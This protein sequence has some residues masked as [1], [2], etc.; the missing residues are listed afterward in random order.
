MRENLSKAECNAVKKQILDAIAYVR[1]QMGY[2]LIS[3]DWGSPEH[4]CTCALGC[5]LLQDNPKDVVR[6]E[7]KENMTVAAELLNVTEAWTQ[8]FL[9]G[10]DN[11]GAADGCSLPDAWKIGADVRKETKPIAY[12]EWDGESDG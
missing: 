9:E 6:I 4:K 10:Y 1:E 11:N 2:T 8:D 5:L 7:A 3:E 12:H